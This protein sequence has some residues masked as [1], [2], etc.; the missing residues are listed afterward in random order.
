MFTPDNRKHLESSFQEFCKRP[1]N[2]PAVEKAQRHEMKQALKVK[3][4]VSWL[5]FETKV[6]L[7][8]EASAHA[9][10]SVGLL[11]SV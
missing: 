7:A 8:T 3:E 1:E 5:E 4:T 10:S 6:S 9:T 11:K 2:R